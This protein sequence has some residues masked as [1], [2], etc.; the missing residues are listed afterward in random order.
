MMTEF[1][2]WLNDPFHTGEKKEF[3]EMK[4]WPDS[5][6]TKCRTD[7]EEELIRWHLNKAYT[8]TSTEQTINTRPFKMPRATQSPCILSFSYRSQ[9]TWACRSTERAAVR[10]AIIG[11]MHEKAL[12]LSYVVY[13]I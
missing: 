3:K 11:P 4:D 2:F 12:I 5:E 7:S 8:K 10:T 9:L 6:W 13:S 1:Y